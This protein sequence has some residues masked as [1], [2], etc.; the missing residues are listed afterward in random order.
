MGFA[1]RQGLGTPQALYRHFKSRNEMILVNR[2]LASDVS[3]RLLRPINLRLSLTTLQIVSIEVG[4]SIRPSC[5]V[6]CTR[7]VVCTVGAQRTHSAHTRTVGAPLQER[8]Q[9]QKRG[10]MTKEKAP[11]NGAYSNEP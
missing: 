7:G 6:A 1:P 5:E 3:F 4:D 8:W 11:Q 9:P 2:Q 10:P